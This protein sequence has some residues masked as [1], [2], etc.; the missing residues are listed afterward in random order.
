MEN[1]KVIS[2]PLMEHSISVLRSEST[3]AEEFRRHA[4]SVAHVLVL[5]ATHDLKTKQTIITTPLTTTNGCDIAEP[6]MAI[7]ILRAGLAMLP[8][9][10]ALIPNVRVGFIGL[11]RDE[12]T[13]IAHQYYNKIP[14]QLANHRVLVIDPMLA[15]GGTM[16][17]TIAAAK[18]RGAEH[19]TVVCIVCAPEGVNRIVSNHPEV[20]IYT[21][22]LDDHLNDKKYIVPGLGDFGDRYFDTL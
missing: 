5:H 10:Q 16:D 20:E 14:D 13:A 6:V 1:V 12:E 3:M 19:I 8:A 22:A 17:D 9:V 15:T 11:E 7:P 21:A 2:H 18:E 4:N